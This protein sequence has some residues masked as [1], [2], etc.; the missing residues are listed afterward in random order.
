MGGELMFFKEKSQVQIPIG[1]RVCT[2][3]WTQDC[4]IND[5]IDYKST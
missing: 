5:I 2:S 3:V 1:S 4:H